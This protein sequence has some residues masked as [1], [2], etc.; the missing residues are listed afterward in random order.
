MNFPSDGSEQSDRGQ[1][2][3]N[4]AAA[5][6]E[7]NSRVVLVCGDDEIPLKPPPFGRDLDTIVQSEIA[8]GRASHGET[9]GD[10]PRT[11]R[12]ALEN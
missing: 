6:V 8:P 2:N 1:L 4:V 3:G 5:E 10:F 7:M 9:E 11:H 12:L